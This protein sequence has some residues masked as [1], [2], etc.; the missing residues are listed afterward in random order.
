MI[1]TISDSGQLINARSYDEVV[2]Q[3]RATS[4]D[5]RGSVQEFMDATADAV[6]LHSGAV[7]SSYDAEQFITDLV[8]HRYLIPHD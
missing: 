7:V 8:E 6:K 1:L 3:L 2:E 4:F 5:P